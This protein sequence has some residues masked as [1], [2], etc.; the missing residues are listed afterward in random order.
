MNDLKSLKAG[1]EKLA[2]CYYALNRCNWQDEPLKKQYYALRRK[3]LNRVAGLL[4]VLARGG[5]VTADLLDDDRGRSVVCDVFSVGAKGFLQINCKM[6]KL[7]TDGNSAPS[8][9]DNEAIQGNQSV[10]SLR[11]DCAKI[12][13][14]WSEMDAGGCKDKSLM[15]RFYSLLEKTVRKVAKLV[16]TLAQIDLVKVVIWECEHRYAMYS[17][18][19]AIEA[20]NLQIEGDL[21]VVAQ[22]DPSP[23]DLFS[24]DEHE[25]DEVDEDGLMTAGEL[26]SLLETNAAPE[27]TVLLCYWDGTKT[28]VSP[29]LMVCKN[30]GASIYANG[31]DGKD[32]SG[33][34]FLTAREL[35]EELATFDPESVVSLCFWNGRCCEISMPVQIGGSKNAPCICAEGWDGSADKIIQTRTQGE[36]LPDHRWN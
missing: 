20:G 3:A 12:A 24:E 26:I 14:M 4:N 8:G 7:V 11:A 13:G 15:K 34:Q 17:A 10:K 32:S 23:S 22:S 19:G 5:F 28:V 27:S 33:K 18:Y 1:C 29:A 25:E 30:S 35:I 16:N 36:T 6:E 2:D 21:D 31:W 9:S